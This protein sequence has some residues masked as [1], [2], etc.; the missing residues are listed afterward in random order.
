MSSEFSFQFPMIATLKADLTSFALLHSSLMRCS[1]S[2]RASHRSSPHIASSSRWLRLRL[3]KTCNP[4]RYTYRTFVSLL[5][6]YT[7]T[8]CLVLPLTRT[9]SCDT[10]LISYDTNFYGFQD[11]LEYRCILMP[12]EAFVR[13]DQTI[14]N[15]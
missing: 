8:I 15:S 5:M 9:E 14:T 12:Q 4:I 1:A 6:R 7:G 3:R 2:L 10:H 11:N 13:Y